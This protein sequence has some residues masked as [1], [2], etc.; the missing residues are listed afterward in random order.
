MRNEDEQDKYFNSE[1]PEDSTSDVLKHKSINHQIN[2]D[3]QSKNDVNNLENTDVCN[4]PVNN[5]ENS[6]NDADDE[7]NNYLNTLKSFSG[8]CADNITKEMKKLHH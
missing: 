6:E 2:Y 1:S 5:D 4:K 3:P 8:T 7:I